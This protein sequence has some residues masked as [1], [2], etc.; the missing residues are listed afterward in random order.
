MATDRGRTTYGC[1]G[2]VSTN[3]C[4][5]TVH[6]DNGL[7][8]QNLTEGLENHGLF[9]FKLNSF[10]KNNK[11]NWKNFSNNQAILI[12]AGEL[13]F[14]W[15]SLHLL[16]TSVRESRSN[17]SCHLF[18]ALSHK[19]GL[20]L[21]HFL[22]SLFIYFFFNKSIFCN[23]FFLNQF[24]VTGTNSSSQKMGGVQNFF[25]VPCVFVLILVLS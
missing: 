10:E 11:S 6:L 3:F 16:N 14:S 21:V 24:N 12:H 17:F 8:K 25:T 19:V 18:D 7:V 5:Y 13:D 22:V 4:P 20:K 23:A 1:H 9:H 15:F 2:H